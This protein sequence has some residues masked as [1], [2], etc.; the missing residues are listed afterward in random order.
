MTMRIANVAVDGSAGYASRL[1]DWTRASANRPDIVTLQKVGPSERFP[2]DALEELGYE[3]RLLGKRD[4]S[5]LGV[6]VMSR[7][8]GALAPPKVLCSGLRGPDGPESRFLAVEIGGLR[9][10]SV[11]APYGPGPPKQAIRRRVA[12][13]KRLRNYVHAEGYAD[14]PSLLCGDFNVRF[15]ADGRGKDRFYSPEEEDAL[16][17]LLDLGFCD[18]YRRAHPDPRESPG[19]TRGY[20]RRPGGTSRL[21]LVL[22]S[23]RLVGGL[24]DAY[25]D[26]GETW[27][28]RD[29]PP[30]IVELAGIGA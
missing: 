22:A 26:S 17:E 2:V 3:S 28:R 29:A 13:L 16:N 6:A 20:D 27:P 19:R 11:Y 12:W 24:R 10:G 14:R 23:E 4:A 21:H 30:L 1:C 25:L 5:D 15:R 9:V 18:L 7:R 8:G